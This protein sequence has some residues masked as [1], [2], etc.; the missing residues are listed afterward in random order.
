MRDFIAVYAQLRRTHKDM[1][2]R[3]ALSIAWTACFEHIDPDTVVTYAA[4]FCGGVLVVMLILEA[5]GV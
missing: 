1:K 5:Y 2:R 4:G 3:R